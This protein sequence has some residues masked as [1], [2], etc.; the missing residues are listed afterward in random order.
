MGKRS[1]RKGAAAERELAAELQR[2]GFGD[3][4]RAACMYQTGQDAPDVAGIPGVHVEVK[5]QERLRLH[6][7]VDQAIED[8]GPGEV[9]I[10][11]HRRNRSP[12]L[13]T[14]RLDDLLALAERV[15]SGNRI[16][17]GGTAGAPRGT[18]TP[19]AIYGQ[20]THMKVHYD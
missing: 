17:R 18:L 19:S 9:P 14:V 20:Q 5:R 16:D 7:A 13:V 8:A 2:L 12:W 3:A 10:V 4:H 15:L 1:Q 6:A 11:A